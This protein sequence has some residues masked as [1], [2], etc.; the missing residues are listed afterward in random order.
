MN[1][2]SYPDRLTER[3]W[4]WEFLRRCEDY[5]ADFKRFHPVSLA[6]KVEAYRS[7]PLPEGVDSWEAH[8]RPL[9]KMVGSREKYGV[10]FL[11]DPA[12][13]K[14]PLGAFFLDQCAYGV[15]FASE[16]KHAE[17]GVANITLIAFDLKRPLAPQIAKAKRQLGIDQSELVGKPRE[18][19]NHRTKW[20]RYLRVLDAK[21]AD[22][23]VREI[24]RVLKL[25]PADRAAGF[26]PER[27]VSENLEQARATQFRFKKIA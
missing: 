17:M 13:P 2:K 11:Y 3:Q 6:E 27:L 23:K 26:D 9:A 14:P 16:E 20:A 12:K 7:V 8:F 22:A 21:A 19:R 24:A 4:Q 18:Q 1:A 15:H 10:N 5:Q 25:R